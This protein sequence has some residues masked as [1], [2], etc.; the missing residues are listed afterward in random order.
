MSNIMRKINRNTDSENRID[1]RDEK[2]FLKC[3][4]ETMLDFEN[5]VNI[6]YGSTSDIL[7]S[8]KDILQDKKLD[9]ENIKELVQLID[10]GKKVLYQFSPDTYQQIDVDIRAEHDYMEEVLLR[11]FSWRE[12]L[13][14]YLISFRNQEVA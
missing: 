8:L 4:R 12:H 3:V 10:K 2:K 1:I 6:G 13:G 14:L 7:N 9:L 5:A 11:H